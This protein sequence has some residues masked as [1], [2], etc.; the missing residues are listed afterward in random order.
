LFCIDNTVRVPDR[1]S[2]TCVASLNIS[3]PPLFT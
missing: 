2:T 1:I 3:D